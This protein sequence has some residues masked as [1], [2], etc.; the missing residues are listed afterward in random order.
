MA[1]APASTPLEQRDELIDGL[2]GVALFGILAVNIQAYLYGI[3]SVPMGILDANS[4]L[5]DHLVVLLTGFFLHYKFYPVFCFCFGY[6]FAVQTRRWIA[7]G[8]NAKARF[9]RRTDYLL[10]LG[11]VHGVLLW[12][13][14]ILTTYA[15]AGKVLARHIGKGPRQLLPVLKFWLAMFLLAAI[16]FTILS[17]PTILPYANPL[18]AD[19]RSALGIDAM[20]AFQAYSSGSFTE[21]LVQRTGEYAMVTMGIVLILPEIMLIFLLG[22]I[23][24]QLSLIRRR[25]HYRAFWLSVLRW[26]LLI[27]IPVNLWHAWALWYGAHEPSRPASLLES[28]PADFA[29]ILAAAYVAFAV[30]SSDSP[31][32]RRFIALFA[33][34][35]RLALS[36]YVAQS[37]CMALLLSGFGLGWGA[38][39]DQ[40][41]L[42]LVAVGIYVSLLVMSHVLSARGMAGPLESAW[43]RHTDANPS[44]P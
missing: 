2:R 17:A 27:G 44:R 15:L 43:R 30:L 9:G 42:L 1:A 20:A 5:A 38:G 4:S 10:G 39:L 31:W 3:G 33:P 11:V 21:A 22:A 32:G 16:L 29:P 41:A 23:T 25:S 34:A 35:G 37:V 7:Q 12:F 14:D 26:S 13:G 24:A 28:F 18:R 6:G 8:R 19:T 40:V 36:N